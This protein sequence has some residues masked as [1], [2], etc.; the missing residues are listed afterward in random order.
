VAALLVAL[1]LCAAPAS[2]AAKSRHLYWGAW[3]GKQLTGEEPPW[4][5]EAAD[6]FEARIGRGL[7]LIEFSAPFA[8]CEPSCQFNSFPLTPLEDIRRHGAIPVF[9]WNSGAGGGGD[10]SNFGLAELRAGRYDRY[11]RYFARNAAAWG[12]PF[13]LRFDWEM[14]GGWFPWGDGVNGN[15]PGE[16]I[17]AWRHVHRIFEEE[18]ATNVTWVWCPFV[19]VDLARFYPGDRYVDWTGLDG[20]NWG[21]ES[22]LALPWQTFNQ[23]FASSYR[24]LARLAPD[25]PMMLGE[26][27]ST[28]NDEQKTV[29]IQEMFAA[30]RRGYPKVRGLVW[31][32]KIDR[33][34][35]WPIEA[36]PGATAAF[37]AGLS[38][39]FKQ[40][41]YSYL[42]RSPI[43]PPG[44]LNVR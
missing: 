22:P 26:V 1:A 31:F 34:T 6:Q 43:P 41:I 38:R 14:N 37:E 40:N 16:F 18:G 9:S 39:G 2:A 21:P 44:G 5:M 12:W 29:W 36:F 20:Y 15:K 4:D 11:I 42:T 3:I 24:Q 19:G 17:P 13:F 23:L 25:K 10:Q 28:G 7:S 27:A 8:Q 33:G 30:L 35:Q 32:N